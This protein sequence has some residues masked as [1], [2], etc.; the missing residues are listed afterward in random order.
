MTEKKLDDKTMNE[1]TAEDF[2]KIK[3]VF[4]PGAF[5]SFEGSQE[6]LDELMAQIQ[7]MVIDGSLFEKSVALD[8]LDPAELSEIESLIPSGPRTLQ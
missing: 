6:E 7:A 3:V 5:D 2:P 1:L 4:A 8:D